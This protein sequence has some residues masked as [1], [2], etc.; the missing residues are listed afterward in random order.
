MVRKIPPSPADTPFLTKP[1][2]LQRL[3][4]ILTSLITL[5]VPGLNAEWFCREKSGGR[6]LPGLQQ[7]HGHFNKLF[8]ESR[9]HCAK[10]QCYVAEC[11]GSFFGYCN[12]DG[13][14]DA[15]ERSNDRNIVATTDPGRGKRCTFYPDLDSAQYYVY[16]HENSGDIGWTDDPH[17][18]GS[19]DVM[20]LSQARTSL[21]VV[22]VG[23]PDEIQCRIVVLESAPQIQDVG[24]GIQI[25]PNMSR[26]LSRLGIEPTIKEKSVL[27]QRILVC[28]WQNGKILSDIPVD[29]QYGETAVIHRADLQEALVARTLELGNIKIRLG[30]TVTDIDFGAPAV[31]LESGEKLHADVVLAADGAKSV[32]RNKMFPDGGNR[33]QPTGDEAFRILIPRERMIEDEELAGLIT[34]PA[35]VRWV[36]PDRHIVGYPIRNHQLY[37]A[38]FVHPD[39]GKSGESWTLPGTKEEMM[40]VFQ[41]WEPRLLKLIAASTHVLKSKLCLH[42]PLETWIKGSCT[43]VGDACH[44]M[45]PYIAQGAAQA[46]EDAAALGVILSSIESAKDVPFALAVYE[47]CRKKRAEGVQQSGTENRIQLHLP[48]GPE[49]IKRDER[50]AASMKGGD[51]PDKWN[52]RETQRVLW[53]YDAE[54]AA[55]ARDHI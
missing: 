26:I 15:W 25:A 16:S 9:L 3:H 40:E 18:M 35:A 13:A 31:Y 32:I 29:H 48:D 44:P 42:P 50:F 55:T 33:I 52:D 41:G 53:G 28:R 8:G 17:G 11:Q 27:L 49:Q 54:E 39:N 12:A 19:D 36:G 46:L 7:M 14:F 10:K 20:S 43:L 22:V 37:N 5:T 45:L 51:S 34:K 23:L 4:L 21:E 2:H 1:A 38:V 47:R 24:A 6:G 30:A